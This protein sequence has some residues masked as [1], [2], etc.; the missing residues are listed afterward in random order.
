MYRILHYKENEKLTRITEESIVVFLLTFKKIKVPKV[1]HSLK[2]TNIINNNYML[3]YL[4]YCIY[5]LLINITL[6]VN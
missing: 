3:F 2:L 1:V 4:T 6:I 5:I